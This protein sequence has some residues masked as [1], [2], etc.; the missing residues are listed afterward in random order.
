[1][2]VCAKVD[3][4]VRTRILVL[5]DTHGRSID[6]S[7]LNQHGVDV[8]IHCGDLTEH[9][10]LAEFQATL[11]LLRSLDAP[12][13]LVIAGNHDFT[14]DP[15]VFMRKLAEAERIAVGV[16][17]SDLVEREFGRLGEPLQML[18]QAEDGI[19]FLREGTY[20]FTLDNGARLKVYASPYTLS[21]TTCGEE[22]WAFQYSGSHRFNIDAGTDV[23]VTHGP[24]RG[25]MD[26][27]AEKRRI[28]CPDLFAAVAGSQPKMHC[29][30]HVHSGWGAKLVAWRSD[31]SDTPS[32]FS[33]IDHGRSRLS[34]SL[35]SIRAA[36]ADTQQDSR[37]AYRSAS[38]CGDEEG[39]ADA[40]YGRT[41]MTNA[42]LMADDGLT[43]QPWMVDVDL[44][45][46]EA[47][48]DA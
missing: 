27:T 33:D 26:M 8:V 44:A 20:T 23:V 46:A 40:E 43:Q 42:A 15:A 3:D 35:A 12:L 34:A 32:H 14:L 4:G 21:A 36:A 38:H 13:K 7:S 39:F 37:P 22:A 30:G 17:D 29:F 41:M 19:V 6:T 31:L 11:E 1:M 45:R 48:D 24:P 25:I 9:S 5:S 10:K 16:L 47:A 18:Q 28:G 2:K